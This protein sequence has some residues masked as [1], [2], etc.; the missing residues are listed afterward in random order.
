MIRMSV[1]QEDVGRGLVG[2]GE[3]E[4]PTS[5]VSPRDA[6]GGRPVFFFLPIPLSLR[7][8]TCLVSANSCFDSYA[9]NITAPTSCGSL[10]FVSNVREKVY[11]QH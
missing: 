7:D 11:V 8:I 2:K 3:G 6:R 9:H 10:L 4:F 1:K 5:G